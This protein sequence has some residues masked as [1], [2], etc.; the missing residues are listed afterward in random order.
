M[1]LLSNGYG[2]KSEINQLS[3]GNTSVGNFYS[4]YSSNDLPAHVSSFYHF[5]GSGDYP[6]YFG[7]AMIQKVY[8]PDVSNPPTRSELESIFGMPEDV[9]A[10]FNIFIDDNGQ[11]SDFYQVV[12]DGNL[13]WVFTASAAH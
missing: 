3:S 9:G 2:F 13:W 4:Y 10:G 1:I 11:G 6:S 12:S 7:G 8:T 5:Y